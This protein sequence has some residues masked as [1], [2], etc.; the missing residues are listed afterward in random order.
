MFA[1]HVFLVSLFRVVLNFVVFFLTS[2]GED[3]DE[4]PEEE[5]EMEETVAPPQELKP[6]HSFRQLFLRLLRFNSLDEM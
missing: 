3:C 6:Y 4:D 1:C 2:D 5:M